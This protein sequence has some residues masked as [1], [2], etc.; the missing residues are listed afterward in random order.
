MTSRISWRKTWGLCWV[1]VE[2]TET[3]EVESGTVC[4]STRML[5]RRK[6]GV[7]WNHGQGTE[8]MD[9]MLVLMQLCRIHQ[10]LPATATTHFFFIKLIWLSLF[11]ATVA[12]VASDE[13]LSPPS[14]VLSTLRDGSRGLL[15]WGLFSHFSG[16]GRCCSEHLGNLGC[17]LGWGTSLVAHG[18]APWFKICILSLS[19]LFVPVLVF[20]RSLLLDDPFWD[21]YKGNQPFD[22]VLLNENHPG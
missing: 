6:W 11:S 8:G 18:F 22:W 9:Q 16:S 12:P 19:Q 21:H 14:N 2:R 1:A 5:I 4:Q 20:V 15:T 7:Q 17:L 3:R 10:A 13:V